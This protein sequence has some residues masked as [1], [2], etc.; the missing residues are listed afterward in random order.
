MEIEE[1]I[2][3]LEQIACHINKEI[4]LE[5]NAESYYTEKEIFG[6]DTSKLYHCAT[7]KDLRRTVKQMIY[8]ATNVI[9][10]W[11]RLET[12]GTPDFSL[13][14]LLDDDEDAAKRLQEYISEDYV[15]MSR[16]TLEG[17]PKEALEEILRDLQT[18][19][20]EKRKKYET[21]KR[22]VLI[23]QIKRAQEEGLELDAKLAEYKNLIEK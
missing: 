1:I 7:L 4:E 17:S 8:H 19:N 6:M 14:K 12:N 13:E 5:T 23:W 2:D 3:Y 22:E 11:Y 15:H 10:E 16:S 9:K 21:L 20:D 18:S